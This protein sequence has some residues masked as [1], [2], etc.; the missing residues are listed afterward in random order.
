MATNEDA[1]SAEGRCKMCGLCG[2][3]A[4]KTIKIR[5]SPNNVFDLPICAVCEKISSN[6]ALATCMGCG[7]L[8]WI[9]KEIAGRSID[10]KLTFG[11]NVIAVERCIACSP[12]CFKR[13]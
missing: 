6:Y 12:Y 7:T 11:F 2:K 5:L 8:S 4:I 9:D 10:M 13:A 1:V 3:Q